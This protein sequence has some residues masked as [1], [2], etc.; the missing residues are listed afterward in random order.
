MPEPTPPDAPL[1]VACLCA[2]WCRACDEYRAVFDAA[3]A[4]FGPAAQFA[5]VDIED[6]DEALGELDIENFPTLL[7]ARGD[8]ALFFGVVTPQAG[9]LRRMVARAVEGGLEGAAVPEGAVALAGRVRGLGLPSATKT[10]A[11]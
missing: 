11:G 6:H 2:A 4:D 9:T 8:Q 10:Q 1:L 5:W 7:I 3:A